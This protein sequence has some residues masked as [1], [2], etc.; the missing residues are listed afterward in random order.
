[1]LTAILSLNWIKVSTKM[2]NVKQID[3]ETGSMQTT[4]KLI[5]K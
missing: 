1:M 4:K 5:I 2:L 3:R